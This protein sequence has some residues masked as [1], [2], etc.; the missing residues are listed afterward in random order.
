MKEQDTQDLV[1]AIA[2]RLGEAHLT[3]AAAESLTSGLVTSELGKGPDASTWLTGGV[4]AYSADVKRAVLD[5]SPGPVVS[6]RCAEEMAAGVARLLGADV[7]IS[8]TGSGGPDPMDGREP[9]T[10]FVGWW[11]AGRSGHREHRFEG[12]PAAVVEQSV[13]SSLALLH[14]VLHDEPHEH[15]PGG[16]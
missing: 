12:D 5:V 10:V 11:R 2:R 3:V 4:V 8:T 7:A 6:A 1:E 15:S 14:D 13:R 16:T 9:G